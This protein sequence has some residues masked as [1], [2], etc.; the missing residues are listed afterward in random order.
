MQSNRIIKCTVQGYEPTISLAHKCILIHNIFI[1]VQVSCSYHFLPSIK[2][3]KSIY[4]VLGRKVLLL[5][6]ILYD[7]LSEYLNLVLYKL[8]LLLSFVPHIFAHF[9]YYDSLYVNGTWNLMQSHFL[10]KV[11]YMNIIIF[12]ICYIRVLNFYNTCTFYFQYK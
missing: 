12:I 7:S 9:F 6:Y 1:S 11:S 3:L 2:F 4:F 10:F 5:K 8:R